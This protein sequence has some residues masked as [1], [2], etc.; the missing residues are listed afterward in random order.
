MQGSASAQETVALASA[1]SRVNCICVLQGSA[2]AQETLAPA[3]AAI[4]INCIFVMQGSASAQETVAPASAASRVS[5]ETNAVRNNRVNL[6]LH[7][8][9]YFW[10]RIGMR[11]KRTIELQHYFFCML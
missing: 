2:S 6:I 1:A 10:L 5:A 4:R 3:S 9:L 7:G 8:T 11:V